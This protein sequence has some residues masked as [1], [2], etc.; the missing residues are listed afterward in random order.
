MVSFW[1]V[2]GLDSANATRF[3]PDPALFRTEKEANDW[4]EE[5]TT[6]SLLLGAQLVRVGS[7]KKKKATP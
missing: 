6:A 4:C 2:T 1:L 7:F 5:H 3:V